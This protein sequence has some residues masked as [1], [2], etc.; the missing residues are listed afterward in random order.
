MKRIK[1]IILVISIAVFAVS[2]EY[3]VA[4]EIN[5]PAPEFSL[6]DLEGN[7]LALSD[8]KGKVVL[9]DFWATWCGPCRIAMPYMQSLHEAYEDKGVA[10]LGVNSWERKPDKVKSVLSYNKITYKIL[11]DPKNEVIGKYKV[12]GIPTFFIIDKKGIVRYSYIGLPKEKEIIKANLE[13]LLAE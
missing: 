11:L 7:N 6:P 12:R 10:L 4:Q 1:L 2:N 5:K 9:V 3:I 13:E 8:L